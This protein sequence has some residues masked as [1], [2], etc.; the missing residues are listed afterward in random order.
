MPLTGWERDRY[1]RQLIV[2]D[3]DQEKLKSASVLIAGVGGLGSIIALYLAA[4]GVG[5]IHLVDGDRVERSDLN[6]QVL[7]AENSLGQLKVEAAK[8]RLTTLNSEIAIDV[9]AENITL[10][11]IHRLARGCDLLVDGLDNMDARAILNRESVRRQIPYVY[12]AVRGWE[13]V[14]G[15]F[16]PPH[17][18]CFGCF[19]RE[20]VSPSGVI[21]IAGVVPGIIGLL[22]ATEVLKF[23]MGVET[24]LL[25]RILV[26]D[27]RALTF[28]I[29]HVDRNPQ[30]E[31]CK[32]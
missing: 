22:E 26:Y 28:D 23:L 5:R 27:S 2:A 4:A 20:T 31:F 7:Y 19:S 16:H 8:R 15:L 32:R 18:A 30:C 11:N 12:G 1:V 17:T 24:A 10:E 29:V 14:V 25:G 13:G 21:P 6:R 9:S 3:W